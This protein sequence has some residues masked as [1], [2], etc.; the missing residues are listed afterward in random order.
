MPFAPG[1]FQYVPPFAPGDRSYGG[2]SADDWLS[3]EELGLSA[4]KLR[5]LRLTAVLG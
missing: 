1:D 3:P 5:E 2:S 4:E